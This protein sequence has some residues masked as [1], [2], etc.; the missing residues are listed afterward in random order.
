MNLHNGHLEFWNTCI[1]SS[2]YHLPF[3]TAW[4]DPGWGRCLCVSSLHLWHG[5]KEDTLATQVLSAEHPQLSAEVEWLASVRVATAL[6]RW[7]R[8]LLARWHYFAL[9]LES[10]EELSPFYIHCLTL[11]L[12]PLFTTISKVIEESLSGY[13]HFLCNNSNSRSVI[14]LSPLGCLNFERPCVLYSRSLF[15]KDLNQ[16]CSDILSRVKPAFLCSHSSASLC[17]HAPTWLRPELHAQQGRE[18]GSIL[19]HSPWWQQ[20]TARILPARA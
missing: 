18:K 19:Q 9:W 4:L 7:G 6:Y 13:K 20:S 17:C 15:L 8:I 10:R 1:I 5:P 3:I 2:P 12:P 14:C 16:K 11:D